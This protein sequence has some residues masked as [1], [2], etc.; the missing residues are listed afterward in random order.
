[1]STRNICFHGEIR[2]IVLGHPFLSGATCTMYV[3][4]F[5]RIYSLESKDP[6]ETAWV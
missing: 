1:M 6:D 3:N 2:K 4:G 5:C